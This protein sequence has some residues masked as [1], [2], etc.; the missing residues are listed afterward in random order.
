MSTGPQHLLGAAH[1]VD[2]YKCWDELTGW[3]RHR[4]KDSK[5][6]PVLLEF[7]DQGWAQQI[8]PNTPLSAALLMSQTLAPKSLLHTAILG[9]YD[10]NQLDDLLKRNILKRYTLGAP[11]GYKFPKGK[12][13]ELSVAKR[14]ESVHTLGVIDDGCC[15]A[16][17]DFRDRLEAYDMDARILALWDQETAP[18]SNRWWS[19]TPLHGSGMG[20]AYGT[21]LLHNRIGELL[22]EHRLLGEDGER[23]CYHAIGR[24]DWTRPW[25]SHGA[26]VMH[27]LAGR[28]PQAPQSVTGDPSTWQPMPDVSKLPLIFVQL[29]EQVVAD[30][31]G[32][33][34]GVHVLDGARYIVNRTRQLAGE[35]PWSATISLSLG[36]MAGPHDG[37]TMAEL[38]LRELVDTAHDLNGSVTIVV[39]AGNTGYRQR[40]HAEGTVGGSKKARFVVRV[41]PGSDR[42]SFVEIWLSDQVAKHAMVS[43]KDPSGNMLSVKIGEYASFKHVP[44]HS[45]GIFFPRRSAQGTNGTLALLCVTANLDDQRNIVPHSQPGFWSLEVAAPRSKPET[46]HAWIE[47][48]DVIFRGARRQQ[49][50]FEPEHPG[51]PSITDYYTLG[52]LANHPASP[53]K[54]RGGLHVARAL[55]SA[56]KPPYAIAPYS[57]EGPV[58]PS[59]VANLAFVDAIGQRSA[60]IP[61]VRTAGFFSG[62][63]ATLNG[64]SAAAPQVARRLAAESAGQPPSIGAPEAAKSPGPVGPSTPLPAPAPP[65][66]PPADLPVRR[67]FQDHRAL[68][69]PQFEQRRPKRARQGSTTAP[70][71]S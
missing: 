30:T 17:Q 56:P 18:K 14:P 42:D 59:R 1:R 66:P 39:A 15:L 55:I 38:G 24:T 60:S 57:S 22:N 8:V 61:G 36:S 20:V 16:H 29:P 33:S 25:R 63:R 3:A 41:P 48:N 21:E 47:R 52:S 4:Q 45:A 11:C 9:R 6:V 68:K 10:L 26:R 51:S 31:T 64:T 32:D 67:L 43:V 27:L 44:G 69:A 12:L 13:S 49:T 53:P 5:H 70:S 40:V 62:S 54:E 7:K 58:L 34:I 65:P 2:V 50:R 37:T 71:S 19:R 28:Q 23:R 46:V 35:R